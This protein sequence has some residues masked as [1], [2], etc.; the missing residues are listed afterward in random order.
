MFNLEEGIIVTNKENISDDNIQ[1]GTKHNQSNERPKSNGLENITV[2]DI[3]D[4]MADRIDPLLQL[5]T[6]FF[7]QSLTRHKAAAS[8]EIRMAWIVLAIVV[9]IVG[10]AGMLTYLERIDGATFT[11]LLGLI[12]GY[13]LTFIRDTIRCTDRYLI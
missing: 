4:A 3:I 8:Y 12:V 6:A 1:S 5:L 7:E 11:F 9:I 13:V 2:I 10:V